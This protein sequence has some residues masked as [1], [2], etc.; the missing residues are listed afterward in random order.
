MHSPT[1]A[2][3]YISIEEL[4]PIGTNRVSWRVYGRVSGPWR[5]YEQ[6]VRIIPGR[7]RTQLQFLPKIGRE[8]VRAY[9]HGALG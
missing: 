1:G 5:P 6:V 9:I 4:T 7:S 3:K 2:V 8:L